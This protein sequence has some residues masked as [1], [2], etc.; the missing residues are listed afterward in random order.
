MQVIILTSPTMTS[1]VVRYLGPYQIAWWLRKNNIETQV[2]DFLLFMSEEQRIELLNKFVTKDTKIVALAP[3]ITLSSKEGADYY[4]FY[5]LVDY[6]RKHFPWVKLV[7]GGVAVANFLKTDLQFDAIFQGESEHSFLKYCEKILNKKGQGPWTIKNNKKV[8]TPVGVYEI[9]NCNQVYAVND[10]ILPG[11]SMPFESA[12]GC[13]FKCK[14]CQH[15]NIGKDKDDFIKSMKNIEYSLNYNL[16]NFGITRYH[17]ADDTF[18]SHR[19]R[20]KEFHDIVQDM[21]TKISWISYI[22]MDLLD[23]WPEQQDLILDAGCESLQFGVESLNEESCRQ[24]GKGWGAKNHKRFLTML[25]DKW[26]DRIKIICSLITGLGNETETDWDETNTFFKN[27]HVHNWIFFPLYFSLEYAMSEF[28]KNYEKY[29]YTVFDNGDWSK[30][31]M[32][33]ERAK[34]WAENTNKKN[35][36]LRKPTMWFRAASLNFGLTKE[37][38]DSHSTLEVSQR[39]QKDQLIKKFVESYY[40]KAMAY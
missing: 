2:L 12:R 38:V 30:G 11:E 22:R 15:P 35:I 19:Q 27:S 24:I 3:F 39:I 33:Y 21:P 40:N 32:A 28:E 5:S 13:I 17:M 23:I 37:Y 20:F 26:G 31:N 8:F 6:V 36:F 9:E 4:I 14:F 7:A 29:G 25:G 1:Y 18:N 34:I 16:E 10:F